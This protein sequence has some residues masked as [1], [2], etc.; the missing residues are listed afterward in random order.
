M[1]HLYFFFFSSRR[2]HTRCSRDWSSDVCSS[3]LTSAVVKA[4]EVDVREGRGILEAARNAEDRERRL[5]AALELAPH[6][7]PRLPLSDVLAGHLHNIGPRCGVAVYAHLVVRQ[8]ARIIG[9]RVPPHVRLR[10]ERPA[11]GEREM[12]PRIQI[13]EIGI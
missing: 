4:L 10:R 13:A 11:G 5:A 3:D 2:R 1:W 12:P 7:D 8:R 9:P 6:R